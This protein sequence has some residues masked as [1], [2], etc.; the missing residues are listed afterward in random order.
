MWCVFGAARRM[1]TGGDS[2]SE[3]L[4]SC[5]GVREM[6]ERSFFLMYSGSGTLKVSICGICSGR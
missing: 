2:R 1:D 3:G 4:E 6:I 5:N